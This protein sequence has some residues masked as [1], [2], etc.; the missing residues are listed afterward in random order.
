MHDPKDPMKMINKMLRFLYALCPYKLWRI[1]GKKFMKLWN[2]QAL[3][4][5]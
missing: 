1:Q 4:M 3:Q 2:F 5:A